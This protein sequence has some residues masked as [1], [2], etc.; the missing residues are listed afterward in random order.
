MMELA[1]L[2]RACV[3][4]GENMS[5]VEREIYFFRID[6][7]NSASGKPIS[8]DPEPVL[9]HIDKLAWNNSSKAR[10]YRDN[11]KVTGCWIDDKKMSCKLRLGTIRRTGLP[12]IEEFGEVTPLEISEDSGLVDQTHIVFLG[13]DIIGCDYNFYGPRVTRLAYYLAAKA[14][15]IAPPMLNIRPLLRKDVYEQLQQFSFIKLFQLRAYASYA[16]AIRE[17]NDSLSDAFSAAQ[18][19]GDADDVEIVLRASNQKVDGLDKGLLNTAMNLIKHP[20]TQH[21]AKTFKVGGFNREKQQNMVLDLLSDKLVVKKQVLRADSRSREL[22][23][24]SAY[25]AIISAYNET[26]EEILRAVSIDL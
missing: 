25:N 26:R 23:K 3:H 24:T 7:G 12:Q 9:E 21:D 11:D 17:N 18:Q 2:I 22:N 10:Y 15:G 20:F 1:I 16:D 8:F 19:A 4:K 14:P 5:T 13:N 6:A